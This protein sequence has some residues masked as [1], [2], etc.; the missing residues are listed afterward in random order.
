M[1]DLLKYEE[2]YIIEDFETYK[3][4]YRRKKVLSIIEKYQSRRILEIGVGMDPIFKYLDQNQFD[5]YVFVEPAPVFF[6]NAMIVSRNNERIKGFNETFT[7]KSELENRFDLI[8]CSALLHEVED[9]QQILADIAKI[10]GIET[11]VHINVPNA[12]SFHRLL[13]LAMGISK[14]TKEFG[15]RNVKLQQNRIFDLEELEDLVGHFFKI[16]DKGDY[17]IKP[18]THE[19]MYAMVQNKIIDRTVLDGLYEMSNYIQGVGSEIFVNCKKG[20]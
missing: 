13:A 4:E 20:L 10:C 16:I 15:E 1:R 14:N 5:E 11:I 17:F 12:N 6:N 19:Q 8:I 3:V 7:F 2:S 9:P 18:F